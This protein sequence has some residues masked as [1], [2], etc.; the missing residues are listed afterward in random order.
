[1]NE[2]QFTKEGAIGTILF[3]RPEKRNAFT[4]EMRQK[5]YTIL[6]SPEAGGLSVIVIRSEGPMFC[7]G[8]DLN[9]VANRDLRHLSSAVDFWAAFRHARPILICAVQ[10]LALGLGA[11]MAMASDLVVAGEDAQFGYPEIKHGLVAS[12]MAVGLQEVVGQRKAFEMVITSRRVG[13]REALALGMINEVVAPTALSS[14]AYALAEEIAGHMPLA[15]HTTKKFFYEASEMPFSLGN[16]A[17]ERVVEMMRRNKDV[18]DRAASFLAGRAS[19]EA[20]KQ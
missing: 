10:G 18:Q 15:V 4:G 16:R 1:M 9:E 2:I 17:S 20:G 8:A 13:A 12:Y 14:R 5:L 3:N 11:G 6:R 19:A 7:A